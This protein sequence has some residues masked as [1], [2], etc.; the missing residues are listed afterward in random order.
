MLIVEAATD[1]KGRKESIIWY[2]THVTVKKLT[3]H[4]YKRRR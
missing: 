3:R 1:S 4:S 2:I